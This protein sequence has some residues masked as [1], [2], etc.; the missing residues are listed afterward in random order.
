[1]QCEKANAGIKRKEGPVMSTATSRSWKKQEI[2]LH[3]NLQK[4]CSLAMMLA[5]KTSTR[6]LT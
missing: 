3:E 4:E 6:L 5:K 1:M 2:I